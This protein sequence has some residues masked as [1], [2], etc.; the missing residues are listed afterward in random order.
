MKI[1]IGEDVAAERKDLGQL[2]PDRI[3]AS[4]LDDLH[5]AAG[6]PTSRKIA[7]A[8]GS[9]S[10][11]TIADTLAGRRVPSWPI[12]EKIVVHL[13]GDVVRFRALW[14]DATAPASAAHGEAAVEGFVTQYRR[15]VA[16]LH[17]RLRN[18]IGSRAVAVRF[19]DAYVHPR[20]RRID[21]TGEDDAE[22]LSVADLASGPRRILV[23]GAPGSGKSTLCQALVRHAALDRNGSVPFLVRLRDFAGETPPARSIVDYIE[24]QAKVLYQVTAPP[25]AVTQLLASGRAVV[26]FD[27][28]DELANSAHMAD[29]AAIIQLFAEGF[30]SS[31]MVITSREI[32]AHQAPF[33]PGTFEKYRLGDFTESDVVHY[34]QRWFRANED[35]LA[36][37]RD[38]LANDFLSQSS[39]LPD[40]RRN[41][42][43]LT[44]LCS[45]YADTGYMPRNLVDIC[46]TSA[47]LLFGRWDSMRG[48]APLQRL[49]AVRSGLA[50]L[51]FHVLEHPGSGMTL[52]G[53]R[54]VQIM[55][56][57]FESRFG[58]RDKAEDLAREFVD[59]C[60]GRA[61]IFTDVGTTGIDSIYGFTHLTF[62]EYFAAL[63]LVRA[64]GSPEQLAERLEPRIAEGQW[65]MVGQFAVQ[66]MDRHV[67]RGAETIASR[68]LA[69]ASALPAMQQRH[70]REFVRSCTELVIL[71]PRVI[72][73]LN[74][75]LP[76]Q[77]QETSDA[78]ERL[79]MAADILG[80]ARM[81]NDLV[82]KAMHQL[83]VVLTEAR[84]GAG[85]DNAE[86]T[87]QTTGDGEFAIFPIGI[88]ESQVVSRF[89]Q[90]LQAELARI[91][92]KKSP[93]ARL[94]IRLAL[95]RGLV[96]ITSS[97]EI[98]AVVVAIHRILGSAQLRTALRER[99]EADF[100]LGV[101]D[102]LLRDAIKGSHVSTTIEVLGEVAA[103]TPGKAFT[104][105]FWLYGPTVKA[106]SRS[107]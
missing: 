26:V 71:P 94:R 43:L 14:A 30:P 21:G 45:L 89:L 34:V 84:R 42:L 96:R 104:E 93:E 63:H 74:E 5:R 44:L 79:C 28:L 16:A 50:F 31:A 59:F 53:R 82:E 66:L 90:S 88:D 56:G 102:A 107:R 18:L 49:S 41:P 80:I 29:T 19:D 85:I 9:V 46:E 8:V 81:R 98:G 33:T 72:R 55:T 67:E 69:M 61:W 87:F 32:A 17:E 35:L 37:D 6:K 7:E 60:T 27:G 76:H 64:S 11:T 65:L 99:P 78:T 95:H 52:T 92:Q 70:I 91:N 39:F 36:D 22:L 75:T 10:H 86:M 77:A 47:D 51:A 12:L 13:G 106:S 20:L 48:I 68:M 73:Q 54:A 57:Y 100:V 25:G 1:A 62:Q 23:V 105:R 103:E 83:A 15:Q 2:R 40:L 58:D 4:A 38:E 24:H 101:G 3:L 97:G